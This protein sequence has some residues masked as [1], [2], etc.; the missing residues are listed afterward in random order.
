MAVLTVLL[1][2]LLVMRVFITINIVL[3]DRIITVVRSS[4]TASSGNVITVIV[5]IVAISLG[6]CVVLQGVQEAVWA[7]M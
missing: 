2:V 1:M 5:F 6:K 7:N 4:S 3:V